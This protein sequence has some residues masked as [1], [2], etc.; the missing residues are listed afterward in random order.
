MNILGKTLLAGARDLSVRLAF[1]E[2]AYGALADFRML[3][4]STTLDRLGF[5]ALTAA[6][7]VATEAETPRTGDCPRGSS[8]AACAGGLSP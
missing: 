8:C 1:Y 5:P 3:I 7:L 4:R 6:Q 2:W